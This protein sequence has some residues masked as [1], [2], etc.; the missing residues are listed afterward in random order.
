MLLNGS[1]T[2][3]FYTKT[4]LQKALRPASGNNLLSN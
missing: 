1:K 3:Q 4:D 2:L